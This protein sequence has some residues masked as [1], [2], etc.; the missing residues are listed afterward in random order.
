MFRKQARNPARRHSRVQPRELAAWCAAFRA[1]FPAC[2]VY[3]TTN[4]ASFL[5]WIN[6]RDGTAAVS[7]ALAPERPPADAPGL[8]ERIAARCPALIHGAA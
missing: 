8:I 3:G 4:G 5:F 2:K 1:A 7:V 6:R